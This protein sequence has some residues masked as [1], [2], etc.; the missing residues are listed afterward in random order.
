MITILLSFDNLRFF[1]V[2]F[3]LLVNNSLFGYNPGKF[4]VLYILRDQTKCFFVHLLVDLHLRTDGQ[5]SC[6]SLTELTAYKVPNK[7]VSVLEKNNQAPS[8]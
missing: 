2:F 5:H 6:S 8:Q 1:F 4:L 3:S 7:L